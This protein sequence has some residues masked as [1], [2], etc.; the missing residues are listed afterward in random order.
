MTSMTR[1]SINLKFGI[2]D[3]TAKDWIANRLLFQQIDIT[4]KDQ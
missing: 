4:L 1:S 3:I 2:V